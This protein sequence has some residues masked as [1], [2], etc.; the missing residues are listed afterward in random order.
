MVI[1]AITAASFGDEAQTVAE[2]WWCSGESPPSESWTIEPRDPGIK[3]IITF[4]GP[5]K[6]PDIFSNA[7]FANIEM[8]FPFITIHHDSRTIELQF[9]QLPPG[10]VCPL[11]FA[12][13]C[14]LV[15]QFGPLAE[16]HWS[17]FSYYPQATFSIQFYV[18]SSPI[19][20]LTPNGGGSL[21]PGSIYTVQWRD[22]R[23]GGCFSDYQMGYLC[24]PRSGFYAATPSTLIARNKRMRGV[25]CIWEKSHCFE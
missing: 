7:C 17:F 12:P 19:K 23:T 25:L 3:D 4:C 6:P 1:V 24:C 5:T 15:G 2:V 14:G 16:G 10:L 20:I 8:G 22:F 21:Q 13:V 11:Y 18:H 9:Q